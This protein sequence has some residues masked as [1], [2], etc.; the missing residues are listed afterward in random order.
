MPPGSKIT[1]KNGNFW[2]K[3][4]LLLKLKSNYFSSKIIIFLDKFS[5]PTKVDDSVRMLV[6][7]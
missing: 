7:E 2:D 5:N 3:I 4:A 6:N 1:N